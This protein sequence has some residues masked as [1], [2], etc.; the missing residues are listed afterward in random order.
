MFIFA[1]SS[2]GVNYPPDRQADAACS[3]CSYL[4][5]SSLSERDSSQLL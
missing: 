2:E 4:L 3:F 1:A 5:M